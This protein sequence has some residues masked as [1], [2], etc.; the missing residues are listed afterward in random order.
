[1]NKFF[2]V[3]FHLDELNRSTRNRKSRPFVCDIEKQFK[4]YCSILKKGV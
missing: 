1:M 2:K 4:E 3:N